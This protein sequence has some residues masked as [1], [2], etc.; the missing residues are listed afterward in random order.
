MYKPEN[1]YLTL[2]AWELPYT[3]KDLYDK[4]SSDIRLAWAVYI[5]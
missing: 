3:L 2:W 4:I 1:L 5:V